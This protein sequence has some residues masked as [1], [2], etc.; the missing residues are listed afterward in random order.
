MA[1]R[2]VRVVLDTNVL[3]SALVFGGKPEKIF[4]HA[5]KK[6]IFVVTSPYLM[7]ELGE[8]LIKK[9][10]FSVQRVHQIEKKIKQIFLIVSPNIEIHILKDTDDDRVL[11]AAVE[12]KCS[13]IITGDKELLELG[14]FKNIEII[15]ASKFLEKFG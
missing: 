15:T 5:L 3:V 1:R 13:F 14:I 10:N 7:V 9:F 8:T 2:F 6:D 4:Q 11:E 12:G